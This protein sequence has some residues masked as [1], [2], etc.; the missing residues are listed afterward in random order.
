M[1]SKKKQVK[2]L[3]KFHT[4]SFFFFFFT[5]TSSVSRPPA[6]PNRSRDNEEGSL[7]RAA[8]PGKEASKCS[9]GGGVGSGERRVAF[10]D[11]SESIDDT[12]LAF[13]IPRELLRPLFLE[14]HEQQ[15]QLERVK[16]INLHLVAA[17][18]SRG[19]LAGGLGGRAKINIVVVREP[20][21][22]G[23]DDEKEK[24]S[25]LLLLVL[26]SS[27]QRRSKGLGAP[28]AP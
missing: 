27:N 18:G 28:Q 22:N 25:A 2:N 8:R 7:G 6:P 3:V 26:F 17:Q 1:A 20:A 10:L 14:Q 12:C 23:D 11:A 5:G 13:D 16:Y 19:R 15:Q 4:L 21:A 9:V 24:E